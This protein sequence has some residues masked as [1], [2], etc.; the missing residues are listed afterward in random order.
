M[1]VLVA[2]EA[3]YTFLE[4]KVAKVGHVLGRV[5]VERAV[6]GRTPAVVHETPQTTDLRADLKGRNIET[7]FKHMLRRAESGGASANDRNALG[8]VRS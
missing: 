1:H 2:G 8:G 7:D 4:Q 3:L 5:D 6:G